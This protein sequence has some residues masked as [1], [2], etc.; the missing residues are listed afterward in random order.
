[1]W[2]LLSCYL[3]F[4]ASDFQDPYFSG[5]MINTTYDHAIQ[6]AAAK[7]L[8]GLD[9]RLLKAQLIQESRLNPLAKSPVGA[10]G[11]AQFM[12]QTWVEVCKA[13]NFK[14][15]EPTNPKYAIPAAAYYMGQLLEQWHADRPDI[16]RYC[17]ALASYNAGFGNLSKAQKSAGMAHSYAE[18][19]AA[20]PKITGKHAVETKGYATRIFDIYLKM[21]LG[22]A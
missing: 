20:L 12:P 19:I 21:V 9:W 13:L 5:F 11:I 8:P 10:L 1:M 3:C 17:L 2:A 16:D 7:Y 4:S 14:G 6:D 18:I 22:Q 15:V